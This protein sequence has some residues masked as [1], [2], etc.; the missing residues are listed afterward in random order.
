MKDSI[1]AFTPPTEGNSAGQL[2]RSKRI[3]RR[4]LMITTGRLLVA[5]IVLG[6][7]EFAASVGWVNAF[8]V[9]RPS[10]IFSYLLFTALPGKDGLWLD[11][12][13]TLFASFLAFVIGSL[14]GIAV[15][16]FLVQV[17]WLHDV[18]QP[19][20]TL[21]N[22]LPRVA[23]APLFIVWFGLGITSKVVLAITLVFFILLINTVAGA[24]SADKELLRL[25]RVL[26]ANPWVI[27][28]KVTIP[29]AVPSIFAGLSLSLVYAV[30]GVIVGEMIA[31]EHGLGGK[32]VYFSNVF[33]MNK[34][35]GILLFL[36]LFTT[37]LG[38]C[39]YLVERRL[40]RWQRQR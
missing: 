31:S 4:F 37:L 21:L 19:Y 27:F 14:L 25:C 33:Q 24:K 32:V 5:V 40:L 15:G 7:W 3:S 34:V 29:S 16:L 39:M 11:T 22:S 35:L 30:L 36:A 2:V 18:I 9:G 6:V 17:E 28:W 38:Q 10:A 13:Y 23:L 20:L 26:G 1:A 8:I 12:G